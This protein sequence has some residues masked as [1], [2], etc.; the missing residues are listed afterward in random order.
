[1]RQSGFSIGDVTSFVTGLAALGG[2]C[3]AG[4]EIRDSREQREAEAQHHARDENSYLAS[5]ARSIGMSVLDMQPRGDGATFDV[6]VMNSSRFPIERVV[7]IAGTV[8]MDHVYEAPDDL[9]AKSDLGALLPGDRK[10]YRFDWPAGLAESA[11]PDVA[12]TFIDT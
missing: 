6:V 4:V 12:F 1:M 10:S 9:V 3:F 7:V 11:Q 2:H 8:P 5:M